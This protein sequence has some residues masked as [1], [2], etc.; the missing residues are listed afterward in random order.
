MDWA[1][2]I[3]FIHLWAL[4]FRYCQDDHFPWLQISILPKKNSRQTGDVA[5]EQKVLAD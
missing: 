3:E 1:F 4:S 2:P 5:K